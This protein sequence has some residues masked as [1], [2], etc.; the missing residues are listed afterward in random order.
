MLKAVIFD[1]D[2]V[3]IDSEPMHNYAYH[4]MFDEVGI[5]VSK[6]LYESYTGKSTI[7]VCKNLCERFNLSHNPETLVE[8]KR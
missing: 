2:G 1:M 6:E 8:L 7:N 5:Q 4:K 3:I